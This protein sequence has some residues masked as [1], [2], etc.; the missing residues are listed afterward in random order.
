LVMRDSIE[1]RVLRTLAVKRSLFTEIFTGTNDEVIFATL[2]QQ[3]F[4]ETVRELVGEAKAAEAP[5]SVPASGETA[6]DPRQA[7]VQAGVQFL[8]ALAALLN[9]PGSTREANGNGASL[10]SSFLATDTQGRPV[11]QV[12]VPSPEML[13]RGTAALRAIVNKW[14]TPN[15]GS[16]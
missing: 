4:L 10:L 5:A 15:T 7:V 6:A 14:A 13:Q 12:P 9:S 3:A 8:E 16:K 1:E 11:L 2:G